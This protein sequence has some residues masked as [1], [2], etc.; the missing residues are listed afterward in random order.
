[1]CGNGWAIF[2]KAGFVRLL[3]IFDF[4]AKNRFGAAISQ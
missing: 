3:K 1:M 4:R 2:E